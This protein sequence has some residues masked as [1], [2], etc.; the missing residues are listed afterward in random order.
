MP[1]ARRNF[2]VWLFGLA[3]RENQ[4]MEQ[5]STTM[6]AEEK[7]KRL[8]L[9]RYWLVGTFAIVFAAVTTYIGL[10][11]DRNGLLAMQLGLPMWGIVAAASVVIY[12]G[13]K[14][15]YLKNR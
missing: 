15:L 9:M 2:C 5:S 6:S 4:L 11:T 14:F 12:Y 8:R 10:F 1:E 7:D 13:Y 3:E